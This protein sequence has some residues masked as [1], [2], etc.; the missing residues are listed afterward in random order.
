MIQLP[1]QSEEECNPWQS[2]PI[3]KDGYYF[4][5]GLLADSEGGDSRP[6][7]ID[8]ENFTWA[9]SENDDPESIELDSGITPENIQWKAA[10]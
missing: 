6:V 8:A 9:F 4:I 1:N 3:P 2:G 5:R 10:V 7:L